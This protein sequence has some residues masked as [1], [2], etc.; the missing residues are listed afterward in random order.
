MTEPRQGAIWLLLDSS[1]MGGI[2]TH[3]Y[4]LARALRDANHPVQVRFYADY[5]PHPLRDRLENEGFDVACMGGSFAGLLAKMKA[6]TPALIHTHGYKAGILGRISAR[7]THTPVVSTYHAGEPGAGI[8]RVYNWLDKLSAPLCGGLIAVSEVIAA[9]LPSRTRV[10]NNFVPIAESPGTPATDIAFVG[11][12]SHEKG[13]DRF[14]EIAQRCPG[15]SF[16]VYGDGPMMFD[17]QPGPENVTFHGPQDGM[18]QV[19]PRV[20]LLCISSR[21]EGLPMAAL[22]AMANGIP[23]ASFELGAL[24]G[25]IQNDSNGWIV[26]P[27]DIAAMASVI[28][29][30]ASLAP[31]QQAAMSSQAVDTI[32]AAYSPEAVLPEILDVYQQAGLANR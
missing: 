10:I 22:E 20:G 3:V 23:V 21:N 26:P 31:E 9:Q 18:D 4:Q 16:A 2:E 17:L 6:E 27:D 11:R 29:K 12:L 5:G 14:C 32:R 28:R 25:L 1:G 15:L 19:W 7:L 24:P 8:V 13:P 30:W